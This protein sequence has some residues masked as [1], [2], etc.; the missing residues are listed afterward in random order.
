MT[1]VMYD[2]V[3]RGVIPGNATA[4]AG[5]L[6]GYDN[7]HTLEREHPHANHLSIS[8]TG[9]VIAATGDYERGAMTFSDAHWYVPKQLDHFPK[10]FKPVCYASRDNMPLVLGELP[11]GIERVHI[12]VWSAHIGAGEHICGPKTCGASFQADATQ[13]TF[14]AFGR[15][16]DESLCRTGFFPPAPVREP[17][18]RVLSLR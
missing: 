15:N 11:S 7:F 2:S 10:G 16:L 6:D 18:R 8:V 17:H 5:Y 9:L 13:W 12:R 1:E 4:I 3:T 14:T